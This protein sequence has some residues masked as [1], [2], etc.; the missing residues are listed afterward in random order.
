ML[1]TEVNDCVQVPKGRHPF[2]YLEEEHTIHQVLVE[3]NFKAV[4]YQYLATPFGH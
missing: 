1:I 2:F 3:R 4:G